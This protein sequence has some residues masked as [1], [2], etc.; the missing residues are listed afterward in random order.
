[1][2]KSLILNLLIVIGMIAISPHSKGETL[3]STSE[4]IQTMSPQELEKYLSFQKE[5][6]LL[7]DAEIE[8]STPVVAQ[9]QTQKEPLIP[10]GE[11]GLAFWV[12]IAAVIYEIVIRLFPTATDYTITGIIYSLLNLLLP[13]KSVSA[14][15]VSRFIIKKE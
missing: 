8:E 2:K 7:A 15:E 1:M 14:N 11:K 10:L 12:S 9:I 3:K 6:Q 5:A 13:N 4:V